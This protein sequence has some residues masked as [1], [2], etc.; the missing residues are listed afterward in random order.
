MNIKFQKSQKI[1]E[2]LQDFQSYFQ[3]TSLS[4][5][6]FKNSVF[7]IAK[8][9]KISERS[10]VTKCFEHF[11]NARATRVYFLGGGIVTKFHHFFLKFILK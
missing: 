3:I 5:G 10:E 1:T 7:K 11:V 2:N 6:D 8:I 9:L 4:F